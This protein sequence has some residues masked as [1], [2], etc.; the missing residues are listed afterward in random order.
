M[1]LFGFC[2][3]NCGHSS[4]FCATAVC[5]SAVEMARLQEGAQNP[6][7]CSAS[8]SLSCDPGQILCFGFSLL[9]A[10]FI[11]TQLHV[12]AHIIKTLSSGAWCKPDPEI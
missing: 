3:N 2:F 10:E 8:P 7:S 4:R 11:I 9:L 6:D 12:A 1:D 5:L